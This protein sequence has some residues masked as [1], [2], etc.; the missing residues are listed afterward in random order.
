MS[1]KDID[2]FKEVLHQGM[3]KNF[4][5]AGYLSPIMFFYKDGKPII[6]EIPNEYLA[7]QVGKQGLAQ[8]IRKICSEPNVEMAGIIIE[9][10]GAKLNKDDNSEEAKAVL[11][12]E[13]RVSDLEDK[14][15]IIIM[16]VST[17]EGEEA[18]SYIVDPDAKTVGEE[19]LGDGLEKMMGTFSN[20]FNWN[21]N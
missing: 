19:F 11:S 12:G 8:I 9:A 21:K 14:E 1:K 4:T 3:K 7:T 16:I 13:K 17:P 18:I 6:S 2:I 20:F 10:Y 15:D 5:M